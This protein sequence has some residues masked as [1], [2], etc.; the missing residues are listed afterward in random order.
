MK[1]E[2]HQSLEITWTET[3]PMKILL[4]PIK[5]TSSYFSFSHLIFYSHIS[6]E[7]IVL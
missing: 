5:L 6:L 7:I 1:I 2:L 4:I 3:I